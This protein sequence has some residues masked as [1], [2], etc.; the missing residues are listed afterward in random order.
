MIVYIVKKPLFSTVLITF[1]LLIAVIYLSSH[2][3]PFSASSFNYPMSTTTG[4]GKSDIWSVPRIIDWRPCN[5][6][7]QGHLT[8]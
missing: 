2:S 4:S 7:I 5:W 3:S 6:W 1:S 8:G